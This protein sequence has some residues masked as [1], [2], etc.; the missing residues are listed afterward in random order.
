MSVALFWH[1]RDLRF[2]DNAALYKALKSGHQVI[3]VFVFDTTILRTL[4][5]N[6]QRVRFIH[7]YISKLKMEYKQLGADLL[8][9]VGDPIEII[10]ALV[11]EY[12]AKAVFTNR[13]YEPDAIARDKMVAKELQELGCDFVGAKDQVIFEKRGFLSG[14]N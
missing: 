14:T 6:D 8:V 11:K 13:D 9:K 12:T 4:P 1:R 5:G 10:P 2:D 7:L 3:P